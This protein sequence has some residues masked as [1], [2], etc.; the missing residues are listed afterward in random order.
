MESCGKLAFLDTEI[1]HHDVGSLTTK[2]FNKKTHTDKYLSF[3]SHHPLIHKNAVART[4]FNRAAKVC[5]SDVDREEEEL[6]ITT[7]LKENGYPENE[8]KSSSKVTEHQHHAGGSSYC[9][10]CASLHKPCV[11]KHKENLVPVEY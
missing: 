4:L 1:I 8:F 9:Y 7:A 6:H 3:D 2:V 11:R 10:S 5:S